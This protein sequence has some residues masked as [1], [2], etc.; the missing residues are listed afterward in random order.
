[1]EKII[2][3]HD[4]FFKQIFS[5][6]EHAKEFLNIYLPKH[7]KKNYKSKQNLHLQR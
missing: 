2:N 7:I 3:P 4:K 6:E 1:M 5:K